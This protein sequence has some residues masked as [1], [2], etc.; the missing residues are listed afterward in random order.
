LKLQILNFKL[1]GRGRADASSP[2][3]AE[4]MDDAVRIRGGGL[5]QGG[6]TRERKPLD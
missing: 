2:D 1:Q 5:P 4:G 6:D 3:E